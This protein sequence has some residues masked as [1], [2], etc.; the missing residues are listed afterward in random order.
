MNPVQTEAPVNLS[1]SLTDAGGDEVGHAA[2]LSWSYPVPSDL[3]YGW[4]TLVY[5]LQYR[6]LREPDAWKVPAPRARVLGRIPSPT[7]HLLPS[8]TISVTSDPPSLRS[9]TPCGSLRWSCSASPPETTW[10]GSAA[11]PRTAVCGAR[12][13]P[14]CR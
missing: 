13:A 1:F 9:S 3:R 5:E 14:P 12:G 8:R 10:S 4:I 7:D 11:G 2:L 6:R